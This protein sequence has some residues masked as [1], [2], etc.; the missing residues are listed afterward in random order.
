MSQLNRDSFSRWREDVRQ[1]GNMAVK[2]AQRF[3]REHD[4]PNV[5]CQDGVMYYQMSDGSL[6]TEN[7]FEKPEYKSRLD[8]AMKKGN[9]KH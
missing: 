8:A 7:P 3:N 1:I 5:F 9:F 4:I 6:T 2:E